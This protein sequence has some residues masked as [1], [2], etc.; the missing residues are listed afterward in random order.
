MPE[1]CM[2]IMLRPR[3]SPTVL[4]PPLALVMVSKNAL[5]RTRSSSSCFLCRASYASSEMSSSELPSSPRSSFA[6][7]AASRSA[8][9]LLAAASSRSAFLFTR[10][11]R[12]PFFEWS[13]PELV[14]DW[15]PATPFWYARMTSWRRCSSTSSRTRTG[16]VSIILT[17]T[18]ST[19]L[20]DPMAPEGTT[21]SCSPNASRDCFLFLTL[22]CLIAD[23]SSALRGNDRELARDTVL[24][25]A[26]A[27]RPPRPRPLAVPTDAAIAG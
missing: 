4:R 13:V 6:T 12:T 1:V 27:V 26:R 19:N 5:Y 11:F 9:F 16:G 24:R 14:F 23:V 10:P 8:A 2:P 3:P 25:L 22:I 7:M 18:R 17:C 20:G 15:D 21:M